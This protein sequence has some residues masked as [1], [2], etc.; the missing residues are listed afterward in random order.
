MKKIQITAVAF[1]AI[2]LTVLG[3]I[4]LAQQDKYT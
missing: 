1:A 2:V 4:A 3:G